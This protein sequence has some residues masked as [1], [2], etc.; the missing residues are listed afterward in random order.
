MD[1]LP[2]EHHKQAS[3]GQHF[4]RFVM[5][6]ALIL[7]LPGCK[8]A[9]APVDRAPSGFQNFES[10]TF[11]SMD[12]PLDWV[13]SDLPDGANLFYTG[14]LLFVRIKVMDVPDRSKVEE[15]FSSAIRQ[16]ARLHGGEPTVVRDGFKEG[17]P[18][19]WYMI[20]KPSGRR[21]EEVIIYNDTLQM[22][23]ILYGSA[24]EESFDAFSALFARMFDSFSFNVGSEHPADESYVPDL[25]TLGGAWEAYMEGLRRRD[26][27]ILTSSMASINAPRLLNEEAVE[28]VRRR[29]Y[30]YDAPLRALVLPSEQ[31]DTVAQAR[32]AL[33]TL[34]PEGFLQVVEREFI[35][36]DGKWRVLRFE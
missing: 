7:M 15:Q 26:L 17:H 35:L 21:V 20:T 14:E 22:L 31:G 27:D 6:F 23:Y 8:R 2:W 10:A 4:L 16:E 9:E 12:Y 32:I 24:S 25:S 3:Y 33:R 19:R 5:L 29:Y 13:G 28:D 36:E 11:F 34:P 30:P 18:F 1:C